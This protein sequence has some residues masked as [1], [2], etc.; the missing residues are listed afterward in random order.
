M[1]AAGD[2]GGDDFAAQWGA[3]SALEDHGVT[4]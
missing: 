2:G 4:F 1:A 3:G